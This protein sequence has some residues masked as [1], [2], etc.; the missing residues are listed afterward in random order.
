MQLIARRPTNLRCFSKDDG[1]D[2]LTQA[3]TLVSR[4]IYRAP[5]YG[6][7][8]GSNS[9]TPRDTFSIRVFGG[10]DPFNPGSPIPYDFLRNLGRGCQSPY[11]TIG[12]TW[13]GIWFNYGGSDF[14]CLTEAGTGYLTTRDS[15][16]VDYSHF[17]SST[18]LT[19]T[20]RVFRGRRVQ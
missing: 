16:R 8:L 4:A 3:L 7:F 12:L 14:N 19:R 18:S 1:I 2:T 11:F 15:I 20:N 6:R 9:D 13:R 10:R 17:L 5:I